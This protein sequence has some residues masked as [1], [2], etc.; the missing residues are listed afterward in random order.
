MEE[1]WQLDNKKRSDRHGHYCCSMACPDVSTNTRTYID[2][3]SLSRSILIHKICHI[4][5]GISLAQVYS[6]CH[7]IAGIFPRAEYI[8][9]VPV[10]LVIRW[11]AS[12]VKDPILYTCN[13]QTFSIQLIFL[14]FTLPFF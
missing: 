5:V 3:Y 11:L 13:Q 9:L 7:I 2:T 12:F 14:V 4:L 8:Y 6:Y 10:I 1:L